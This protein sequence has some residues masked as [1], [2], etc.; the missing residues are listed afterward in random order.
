MNNEFLM[1]KFGEEKYMHKFYKEGE[2][3]LNTISYFK[4]IE[5]NKMRGD[6]NE[7]L[8]QIFQSD[9]TTVIINNQSVDTKGPIRTYNPQDDKYQ[10]TN[11]FSMSTLCK[12]DSLREDGR[13]FNEKVKGL[14][15]TLVIIY[16][17]NEFFS[18]LQSKLKELEGNGKI[19]FYSYKRVKYLDLNTYHGG[20]DIFCKSKDYSYQTEWRLGMEISENNSNPFSFK[21][22]SISDIAKII[23]MKNF[24]NELLDKDGEI[25]LKF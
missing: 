6:N 8:T 3:Y 11:I 1:V 4:N 23:S 21:I 13:I 2:L 12:G 5:D 9:K 19:L 22:G 18:M 15:N 10:F 16:N 17:L 20:M 25:T 14:G 7:N 24:K